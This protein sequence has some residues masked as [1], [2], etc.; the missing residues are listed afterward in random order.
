MTVPTLRRVLGEENVVT[1]EP[2]MGGEDFSYFE[3][4]VPGFIFR[5]GVGR[6]GREMTIHSST[7]VPDEAG[8]RWGAGDERSDLRAV[9]GAGP[10]GGEVRVRGHGLRDPGQGGE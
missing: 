7:F 2:G 10:A 9:G 6:P 1:Y 8:S 3:K 4:E 5:L